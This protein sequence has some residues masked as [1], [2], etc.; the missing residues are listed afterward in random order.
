MHVVLI[1]PKIDQ[2]TATFTAMIAEE[3]PWCTALRGESIQHLHDVLAAEPLAHLNGQALSGVHID[4]SQSPNPLSMRQLIGHKVQCPHLIRLGDPWPMSPGDHRLPSPWRP[5]PERQAFFPVEAIDH[6][7]P[8][9]HPSR[10][11]STRIL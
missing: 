3:S 10:F 1:G 8:T 2:L 9:A 4:N 11:S 7:V 6:F 5:I